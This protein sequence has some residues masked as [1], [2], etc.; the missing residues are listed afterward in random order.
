MLS[1]P[2]TESAWLDTSRLVEPS[3]PRRWSLSGVSM[4]IRSVIPALVLL[5]AVSPLAL[6]WAGQPRTP[7]LS[8]SG[9]EL[10]S[11]YLDTDG[12]SPE[13][14][15]AQAE[16]ETPYDPASDPTLVQPESSIDTSAIVD[17][18]STAGNGTYAYQLS[19]SQ[20]FLT[21]AITHSQ[22]TSQAQG[23]ADRQAI[24]AY[25]QQA[26]EAA[27][28]AIEMDP[29]QGLGFLMRA[30]VYKTAGIIK[31]ELIA[32]AEQDL[33]I[34]RALGVNGQALTDPNPLQH[35]PTVVAEPEE[36]SSAIV[37]G[38]ENANVYSSRVVLPQGNRTIDVSYPGLSPNM[39]LRVDVVDS[40]Q[41]TNHAI[42]TIVSRREG[43]GFTIQST[44]PV[45][46]D[47][48]LEWRAISE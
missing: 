16:V 46:Q 12:R 1:L 2:P 4:G 20:G 34:A 3:T 21:K 24:L 8:G 23:E 44:L 11:A 45:S 31:P 28:K 41:N 47:V 39:S 17:L 40:S 6:A 9:R 26:L 7:S 14:L 33:T 29:T 25:L 48:L 36:G 37:S 35:L 13:Q 22:A 32:L 27:N 42:F 10:V 30:R 5:A 38:N 19:L 18:A 15:V 43:E